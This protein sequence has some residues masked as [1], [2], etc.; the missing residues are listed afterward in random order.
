MR[1]SQGDPSESSGGA[2]PVLIMVLLG[3]ALFF[4]LLA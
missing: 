1:R 3:I 4:M 2:G